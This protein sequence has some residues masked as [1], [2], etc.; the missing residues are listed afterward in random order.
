M[1]DALISMRVLQKVLLIFV[2]IFVNRLVIILPQ[3]NYVHNYP[4]AQQV[5]GRI[6]F[7]GWRRFLRYPLAVREIIYVND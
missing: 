2:D 1:V 5:V 4:N 7:T 3:F 6:R